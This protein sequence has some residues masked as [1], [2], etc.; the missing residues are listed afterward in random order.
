MGYMFSWSSL[1]FIMRCLSFKVRKISQIKNLLH[2]GLDRS[3]S[4]GQPHWVTFRFPCYNSGPDAFGLLKGDGSTSFKIT[5]V[6]WKRLWIV[7]WG[8]TDCL[9]ICAAR[10]SDPLPK[11]CCRS[12][13]QHQTREHTA[14]L[15]SS[16]PISLPPFYPPLKKRRVYFV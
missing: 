15:S 11:T 3:A 9:L 7:T 5:D 2:I 13:P 12:M 16:S 8:D 4:S 1:Q 14:L 6:H 10:T